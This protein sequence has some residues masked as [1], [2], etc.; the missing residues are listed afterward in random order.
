VLEAAEL[1]Q[2]LEKADYEARVEELRVAL[3]NAQY[4]LRQSDFPVIVLLDG[5]DRR[6]TAAALHDMFD[7][8]DGRYLETHALG[9]LTEEEQNRPIVWR[10]WRRLPRKGRIGVFLNGWAIEGIRRRVLG[11]IDDADFEHWIGHTRGFEGMLAA[12]GALLIKLWF[13]LPKKELKKRIKKAA[14]KHEQA[15]R[16]TMNDER[17]YDVYDDAIPVAERLVNET[18]TG[19]AQ[20]TVI[21]STD[22]RYAGVTAAETILG[23]V[24]RRLA[25][26]PVPSPSSV[27]SSLPDIP[28]EKTV[29]DTVDLSSALSREEYKQRLEDLQAD[30][31]RLTGKAQKKGIASVLAFEGWDAAG[32][33]G[34]IRRLMA[35]VDPRTFRL[36]PVAA[37]TEEE[38]AHHYLWR[39]WSHVPMNGR[40]TV[41]DRSW[42]GRVLVER[43]EGFAQEHEWRRAYGEIRDF[44]AQLAEH[45]CL[46]QKFWL[47]IDSDE[48]LARFEAREQTPYKQYKLTEEDYRNREKWPA[49]EEAVHEMVART[50]TEEAPWYLV[51]ANDKRFARVSVLEHFCKGLKGLL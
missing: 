4:D 29:L 14:R 5:D 16:L 1:G 33:G 48:Q 51:P 26:P 43:V 6:A 49:Y 35:P 40:M 32:K 21:E 11:E 18:S 44:E 10:Y 20:W 19:D 50:H 2:K 17:L 41:F 3:I 39:F 12:D 13:H 24:K 38:L 47:H 8:M 36:I 25:G 27:S 28:G 22:W 30:V 15:W 23:A 9:D 7:W 42:Y 34:V 45:G 31:A 46:V 37:P